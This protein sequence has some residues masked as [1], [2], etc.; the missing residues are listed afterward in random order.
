MPLEFKTVLV[1]G[2]AGFIGYH[3]SRRLIEAG[4]DVIGIDNINSYYDVELKKARLELLKKFKNFTFFKIDLAHM[5][6][7]E[8]VFDKIGVVVYTLFR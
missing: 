7:L 8:K 4:C 5:G 3:L 6:K 1:T 2:A